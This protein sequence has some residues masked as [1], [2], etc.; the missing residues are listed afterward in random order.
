MI[1]ETKRAIMLKALQEEKDLLAF[2]FM[3]ASTPE[4]VDYVKSRMIS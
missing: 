3:K 1:N 2:E 4:E